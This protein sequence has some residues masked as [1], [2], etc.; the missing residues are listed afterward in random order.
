[1]TNILNK[2][3]TKNLISKSQYR[4]LFMLGKVNNNEFRKLSMNANISSP[5]LYSPELRSL[6]SLCIIIH[7][8][9]IDM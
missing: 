8:M 4:S 2:L 6:H 3:K 9:L 5:K 7:H 1:M